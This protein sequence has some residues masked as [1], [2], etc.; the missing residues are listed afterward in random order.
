[1]RMARK[2]IF[3]VGFELP[4]DDFESVSFDSDQSLLDADIILFE[5]DGMV[6]TFPPPPISVATSLGE[7]ANSRALD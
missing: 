4:G 3:T 5:A 1:M 2:K 7:E 6:V